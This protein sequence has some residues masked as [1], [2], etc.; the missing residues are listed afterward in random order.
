[1]VFRQSGKVLTAFL[2]VI[3]AL[4]L[5]EAYLRFHPVNEFKADTSSNIAKVAGWGPSGCLPTHAF[6]NTQHKIRI[7][8]MGDS[9]LDCNNGTQP[10]ENTISYMLQK[11]LGPKYEVI[12]IAAGGWGTDQ[13]YLAY[14]AEGKKYKPDYTLVLF[15]PAND[16]YNNWSHTAIGSDAP[17][18]YWDHL[19]QTFVWDKQTTAWHWWQRTQ[20]YKRFVPRKDDPQAQTASFLLEWPESIVEGWDATQEILWRWGYPTVVYVPTGMYLDRC[21][22]YEEPSLPEYNIMQPYFH[23]KEF[24]QRTGFALIDDI[25]FVKRMDIRNITYDCTHMSKLGSALLAGKVYD[26]LKK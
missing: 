3:L 21:Y 17:K 2:S 14:E 10:Y 19:R 13:E 26:F 7:L 18:P 9:E 23:M 20:I 11:M 24:S 25:D 8:L 6:E 16:I 1:M 4:V 5:V 12:T 15:T 22:G